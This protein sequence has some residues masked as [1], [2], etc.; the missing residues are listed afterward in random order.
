MAP[1]A[2]SVGQASAKK[3]SMSEIKLRRLT[4]L[5]GRLRDD[6]ERERVPVSEACKA[7]IDYCTNTRDPMIPSVWGPLKPADDPYN[8]QVQKQAGGFCSCL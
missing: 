6:L 7:L 2:G 5:N 3:A 8:T 1:Q 4:E